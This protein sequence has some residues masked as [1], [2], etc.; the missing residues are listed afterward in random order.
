M[1][2]KRF[3]ELSHPVGL[4]WSKRNEEDQRDK[5]IDYQYEVEDMESRG[6]IAMFKVQNKGCS[7]RMKVLKT[8]E[9]TN[10][11]NPSLVRISL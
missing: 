5:G 8:T 4:Y 10:K 9:K 7:K 6:T 3:L 11:I 1:L 2:E